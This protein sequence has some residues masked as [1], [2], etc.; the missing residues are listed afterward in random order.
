MCRLTETGRHW[1]SEVAV[2]VWPTV[3]EMMP[4]CIVVGLVAGLPSPGYLLIFAPTWGIYF[5]LFLNY[6][7]FF[8][9]MAVILATYKKDYSNYILDLRIG[10][11]LNRD[12]GTDI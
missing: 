9:Y 4:S 10:I 3:V 8:N 12:I 11:N 7:I 5:F 2:R 1:L 6:I